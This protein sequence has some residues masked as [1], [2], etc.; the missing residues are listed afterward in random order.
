M[1]RPDA[2]FLVPVDCFPF[3]PAGLTVW[4][5]VRRGVASAL[6]YP[7]SGIVVA[8]DDGTVYG[9][10][11]DA[12]EADLSAPIWHGGS[13]DRMDALPLALSVIGWGLS[14]RLDHEDRSMVNDISGFRLRFGDAWPELDGLDLD[15]RI[16]AVAAVALRRGVRR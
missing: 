9:P 4:D 13:P 11:A 10:M 6:R 12:L 15:D 3:V 5:G 1:N 8:F 2:R 16:R 14:I 7:D